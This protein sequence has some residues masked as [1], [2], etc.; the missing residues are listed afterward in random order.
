MSGRPSRCTGP[1]SPPFCWSGNLPLR[2]FALFLKG[3]LRILRRHAVLEICL[4][5][6]G[7]LGLLLRGA[8]AQPGP[9]STDVEIA[10]FLAADQTWGRAVEAALDRLPSNLQEERQKILERLDAWSTTRLPALVDEHQR[11]VTRTLETTSLPEDIS[12]WKVYWHNLKAGV[13]A[14]GDLQ[15][16]IGLFMQNAE[17]RLAPVMTE[18]QET[19]TKELQG[20]L[21]S[22]LEGAMQRIRAPFQEVTL[23][24]FPLYRTMTLPTPDSRSL[25]PELPTPER[26]SGQTGSVVVLV[27]GLM[28]VIGRKIIQRL[29]AHVLRSV[30]GKALAK[31]L[32]ILGWL[33]LAWEVWDAGSAKASLEETM[34]QQF[35]EEYRSSV[36]AASFWNQAGEGSLRSSVEQ[37]LD[38]LLPRWERICREEARA[39]LD[40]APTLA[41]SE[42][43]RDFVADRA[44]RGQDFLVISDQVKELRKIFGPDLLA[45]TSVKVLLELRGAAPDREELSALARDPELRL[46]E[47]FQRS[48]KIFLEAV[49]AMGV[50]TFRELHPLIYALA[51]SPDK[52]PPWQLLRHAFATSLGRLPRPAAARGV[53]VLLAVP[54]PPELFSETALALVGS[55]ESLFA[56]VRQAVNDDGEKLATLF[57]AEELL[58]KIALAREEDALLADALLR[59][60]PATFWGSWNP[61]DLRALLSA[62]RVRRDMF[63]LSADDAVRGLYRTGDMALLFRESGSVGVRL[64]Y[65][66]V[67]EEGGDV[68]K[69]W[70]RE[71]ISLA[72]RGFDP[73][74]LQTPENLSWA[75][76]CALLPVGGPSLFDLLSRVGETTRFLLILGGL[77]LPLLL[78][79]WIIKRLVVL[80]RGIP[81]TPPAGARIYPSAPP[82]E[83]V[84]ATFSEQKTPAL[85]EERPDDAGAGDKGP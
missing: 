59:A 5:L 56:A 31:L 30:V 41:T 63:Q 61:T 26:S 13:G 52:A 58:A 3:S 12:T 64:W 36:T 21:F 70:A 33:L 23:R 60:C 24:H 55:R 69:R 39:Q 46:V 85:P 71:A 57:S 20:E 66:F 62:A 22:L 6:L 68:Q 14:T 17:T 76:F 27:A 65:R 10:R 38:D 11:H 74:K 4:V 7:S 8:E 40:V 73:E 84:D 25:L 77:A 67:G 81:R 48:G 53:L 54:L 43:L 19:L 82:Q 44:A 72:A 78:G 34:R 45:R 47:E 51:P 2:R 79:A 28:L 32:P 50:E 37:A 1:R 42:S 15:N 29:M 75:S 80:F 9:A 49:H 18:F 83:A 35:L 16:L